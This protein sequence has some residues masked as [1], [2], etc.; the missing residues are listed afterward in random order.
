[1]GTIDE[2]GSPDLRTAYHEAGHAVIAWMLH[3]PLQDISMTGREDLLGV[4]RTWGA[5]ILVLGANPDDLD[6]AARMMVGIAGTVA[7]IIEFGDFNE[8]AANMDER[9]MTGGELLDADT[10]ATLRNGVEQAL[11]LRWAAVQALVP[12][13][14][15]PPTVLRGAEAE[16]MIVDALGPGRGQV[17]QFMVKPPHRQDPPEGA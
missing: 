16:K 11:R 2:S 3:M 13:L 15:T 7:E 1:M 9:G 8:P 14:S 17:A 6:Q 4:T 5:H 10:R 12:H